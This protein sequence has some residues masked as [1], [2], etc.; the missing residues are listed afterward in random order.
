MAWHLGFQLFC[1]II[2][3]L[4]GVTCLGLPD[5]VEVDEA[6]VNGFLTLRHSLQK[7]QILLLPVTELLVTSCI[8]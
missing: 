5:L 7:G 4:D 3:S 8:A 2:Y 1:S 6:H